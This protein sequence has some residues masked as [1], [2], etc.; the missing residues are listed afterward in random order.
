M[1]FAV[2]LRALAPVVISAPLFLAACAAVPKQAASANPP[3]SLAPGLARPIPNSGFVQVGEAS[4]YGP[5]GWNGRRTASGE[6]FDMEAMTAAHRSLP[7]G[8]RVRVT[9]AATGR[10]VVVVINDRIGTHRRVIDLSVAAA[11]EL[12]MLG[13]GVAQV[14]LTQE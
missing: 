2:S 9:D 10:S 3:A 8:T 12:D 6:I 11:R 13:R 5:R 14:K 1:K 7:F 4:Y